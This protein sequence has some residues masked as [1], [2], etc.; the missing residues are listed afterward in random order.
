MQFLEANIEHTKQGLGK[1]VD[2]DVVSEGHKGFFI[3]R[4]KMVLFMFRKGVLKIFFCQ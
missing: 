4:S 2:H 1:T 3:V